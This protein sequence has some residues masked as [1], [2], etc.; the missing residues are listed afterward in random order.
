M[1]W[2]F[3]EIADDSFLWRSFVSEDGEQTWQL[4]EEMHVRRK[5]G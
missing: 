5:A 3:S 4:R 1:R 2:T